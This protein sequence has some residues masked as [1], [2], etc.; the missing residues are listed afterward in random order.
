MDED[1][2]NLNVLRSS[3]WAMINNAED[4]IS[5]MINIIILNWEPRKL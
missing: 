5:I 3:I 1:L 4:R 2:A